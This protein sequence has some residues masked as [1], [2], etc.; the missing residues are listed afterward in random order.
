MARAIEFFAN[1][2]ELPSYSMAWPAMSAMPL[3]FGRVTLSA[4]AAAPEAGKS[5]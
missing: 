2:E 1:G 4:L 3:S 5:F